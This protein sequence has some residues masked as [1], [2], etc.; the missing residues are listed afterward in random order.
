MRTQFYKIPSNP[1]RLNKIIQKNNMSH[2][3][4]S[5]ECYQRLLYYKTTLFC[6]H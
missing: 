5:C 1:T 2:S 3:F 6:T 4:Y